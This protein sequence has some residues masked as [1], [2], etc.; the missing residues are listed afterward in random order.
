M[1]DED[2]GRR[3]GLEPFY[4]LG[5]RIGVVGSQFQAFDRLIAGFHLDAIYLR[6]RRILNGCSDRVS[7]QTNDRL[8][9]NAIGTAVQNAAKSQIYGVEMEARYQPIKSLELGANYTYT[10]PKYIK[11][12]EPTSAPGV[13]ID[14][15]QDE[16]EVPQQMFNL[17]A[18]YTAV[19]PTG[20]KLVFHGDVYHQS[21]LFF[22][23]NLQILPSETIL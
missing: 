2:A 9:G 22:G 4:V 17:S 15:S 11:W 20:D 7:G 14:H 6:L 18:T 10:D 1:I 23:Q 19:L 5:I 16:W 8:A 13:F 12:L 3:G 21:I